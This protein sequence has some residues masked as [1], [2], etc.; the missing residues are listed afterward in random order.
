MFGV[1]FQEYQ[2]LIPHVV[3]LYKSIYFQRPEGTVLAFGRHDEI[4]GMPQLGGRTCYPRYRHQKIL[5]GK[6]LFGCIELNCYFQLL[7]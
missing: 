5:S 3:K 2:Q 7:T 4:I 6:S 1:L